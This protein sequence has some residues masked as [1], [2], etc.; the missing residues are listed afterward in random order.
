MWPK[1]DGI[2]STINHDCMIDCISSSTLPWRF[3]YL[4]LFFLYKESSLNSSWYLSLYFFLNALDYDTYLGRRPTAQ[5][6]QILEN[7]KPR[8][9]TPPHDLTANELKFTSLY[10]KGETHSPFIARINKTCRGMPKPTGRRLTS[11]NTGPW[12]RTVVI[13]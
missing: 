3:T 6:T 5:P 7:F 1:V 12:V 13:F 10:R 2:K 11:I 9:D 8:P 4:V